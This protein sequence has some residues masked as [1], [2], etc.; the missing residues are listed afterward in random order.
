MRDRIQT[1]PEEFDIAAREA[2]VLG[3]GQRIAPMAASEFSEDAK[4]LADAVRSLFGVTDFGGIPDIFATMFK[5][6]GVYRSQ[7]QLGLELNKQG[8]LP[9]RDRELAILRTAWLCRSPF[10]WGEHVEVGKRCGISAGEIER[11]TQGSSADG[12]SAHDRALIRAVEE[13]MGDHAIG[14]ESWA[15]LA[16]TWSEMQL[17]E[18]PALVGAYTLTAMLYNTLRFDLLKGNSG[19]AHR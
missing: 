17:I 18:L 3:N 4:Q 16:R 13:L 11:I 12:W 10:E 5:H 14:D 15:E 8:S 2:H 19:L 1:G 7:M 9:P 6:P